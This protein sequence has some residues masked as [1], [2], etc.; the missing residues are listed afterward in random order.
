MKIDPSAI[1]SDHLNTLT[2]DRTGKRSW[3][4]IA[5]FYVAPV[6]LGAIATYCC[7]NV[8]KD[9]YN[10][11]ITFFGIFIA[12]LLNIQVAVFSILQRKI[13]QPKERRSAEIVSERI[14]LRRTLLSQVNA[15][16]SYL[17]LF[18][19]AALVIFLLFYTLGDPYRIST[20]LTWT[21]Y[22]H[23]LLTLLMVVK[24]SH[25]LF[26]SEYEDRQE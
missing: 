2:D 18:C 13:G 26:Q 19:C 7:W 3:Q 10:V 12:L 25:A 23:F 4:D 5:L 24:R 22:G 14:S 6:A 20:P 9:V 21:T 15:N 17:V 16:I 11:S 1:I 8:N